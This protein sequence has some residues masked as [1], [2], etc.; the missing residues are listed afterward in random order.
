MEQNM[1]SAAIVIGIVCWTL[2]QHLRC[3]ASPQQTGVPVA[4]SRFSIGITKFFL[5]CFWAMMSG[6]NGFLGLALL[7]VTLWLLIPSL[8]L[9]VVLTPLGWPRTTYRMARCSGLIEL[10][11]DSG[12]GAFYGAMSGARNPS[13]EAID[14]L[15]QKLGRARSPRGAGITAAALLAAQRGDLKRA[16]SLFLVV[17]SLAPKFVPLGA[18]VIAREWLIIDAAQ[19]GDWREVIRLG[20]RGRSSLRWSYAVARISERSIG[21]PR[22]CGDWALVALWLL[23]SRRRPMLPLLRHALATPRDPEAIVAEDATPESLPEAL[24]NLVHVVGTRYAD[25]ARAVAG[26]VCDV[27]DRLDSPQTRAQV[28]R[29]LLAL[30]A[31]SDVD[32][33]LGG[34]RQHFADLLSPLVEAAPHLVGESDRG[35]ILARAAGEA[36]ARLFK[37]IEAHCQDMDH[38]AKHGVLAEPIACWELWALMR[39]GAERLMRLAPES[40]QA[41]FQVMWVSANNFAVWQQNVRKQRLLPHAIYSWLYSHAQSDPSAL[42]WLARNM[43]ASAS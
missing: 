35:P 23:A 19:R 42:Q 32:A 4:L 13:P 27:D 21:D 29:R 14:W 9:K 5:L 33:V 28:Q 20:R 37:D 1:P 12:V 31:R 10:L 39:N 16:R 43:E 2:V 30:G 6:I 25:D 40:E 41:L 3:N 15:A 18:R 26:A 8:V 11:A 34:V 38:R 17:D 7:P 24:A 36:R 22:G